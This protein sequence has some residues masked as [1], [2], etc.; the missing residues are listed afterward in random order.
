[1]PW[2][3]FALMFSFIV[4]PGAVTGQEKPTVHTDSGIVV[5]ERLTVRG[6]DVDAFYGIPY[7]VPPLGELRF[8]KPVPF[9]SWQGVYHA[10]SK[11]KPCV[12]MDI[13]IMEVAPLNYSGSQEDCLYLNIWRSSKL[14]SAA[15]K[16]SKKQAVV[17]YIHGGAFQWGDSSLFLYDGSNFAAS[18]EVLFVSFNY[19]VGIFGFLSIGR[20]ELP[21]NM[22]LW[23]QSLALE[24]VRTNIG[25]FG[26]DPYQVTL[27][28][29]S[30]GAASVGYHALSPQSRGLFHQIIMQSGTPLLTISMTSHD[31]VSRFLVLSGA[32]GCYDASTNWKTEV[33]SIIAC[34]QRVDARKIIN[35]ISEDHPRN[36][37]YIP[38]SGD[39][40]LPIDPFAENA[41]RE[42]GAKKL[43]IGRT[44]NE[45]TLMVRFLVQSVP[46]LQNLNDF[47]Y[48]FLLNVVFSVMLDIPVSAGRDIVS[49][50]FGDYDVQHDN[51]TVNS[52]IGE[53]MGDVMF[54]CPNKYIAIQAAAQGVDVYMYE[55]AHR[56]SFS[57]WPK[58]FGVAHADDLPFLLG[59]LQS[60]FHNGRISAA[61]PEEVRRHISDIS[62][63]QEELAFTDQLMDMVSTFIKDG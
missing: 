15:V 8:R 13:N 35:I 3:A 54:N 12:Q 27:W 10:T 63:T 5:G 61:L 28:G 21:G 11:P 58:N 16:C 30:A 62:Y 33:S 59:T 17:V 51:D 6:G 9:K 36:Q 22:G 20:P 19:R 41:W 18:S 39:D 47:D 44:S 37:Y 23:D 52:I 1:M 45:G 49:A 26:G 2:C 4:T 14:C 57:A 7:A 25:Y 34:L 24:W 40:F 38:I 55:F 56:P 32:V 29:Q 50:Y 53:V 46:Q 48:R 60:T 31:P 43:L 42:L